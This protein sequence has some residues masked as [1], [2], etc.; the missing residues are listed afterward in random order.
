M[1]K[2]YKI[3]IVGFGSIGR[4][5]LNN[6]VQVLDE[7]ESP[8]TIDLIRSGTGSDICADTPK[9]IDNIFYLHDAT[10]DDYDIIFVT[11]PT[12]LHYE[13]IKAFVPK[14]EHM[15]IEKPVFSNPTADIDGLHLRSNGIY[16]VACPLRYTGVVQYIKKN[17]DP[18]SIYC[19]RAIC[20]S[21]LPE[22]RPGQDYRETYSAQRAMGGGV[23]IDLIHEWDYICH[24]F[25]MP[26]D[27]QNIRGKFSN[28]ETDSD[29]LSLYM[30]RYKNMCVELHLD[31]FGR[32]PIREIQLFTGEDTIVGNILNSE[33]RYLRAGK[34]I[35]FDERRNDCY[36]REIGHFFD[37]VEGGAANDNSIQT[38]QQILR[39]AQGRC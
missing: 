2:V 12:H 5:H 34:N 22:W 20:S 7:R 39:I 35:S 26:E 32:I 24:I 21:Y 19:A 25:G 16:Y 6:I 33:I 14:T 8:Y 27:V 31:Y 17:I 13:T 4:R 15:F 11:N 28:L 37:I 36:T 23:S 29:D 9:H 1:T 18:N 10:P 30:A 3:G 38:A